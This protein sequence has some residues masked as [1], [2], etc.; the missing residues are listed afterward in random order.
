M[1]TGRL[2]WERRAP[3]RIKRS[4]CCGLSIRQSDCASCARGRCFR[5]NCKAARRN[6]GVRTCDATERCGRADSATGAGAEST[7]GAARIAADRRQPDV[8]GGVSERQPQV[9]LLADTPLTGTALPELAPHGAG[10]ADT[11]TPFLNPVPTVVTTK[12]V[13]E[14]LAP[15]TPPSGNELPS[16][17]T[18]VTGSRPDMPRFSPVTQS[19]TPVS[20]SQRFDVP[21]SASQRF[22]APTPPLDMICHRCRRW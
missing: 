3:R 18:V 5:S 14:M 22:E 7:A 16:V 4:R 20:S 10:S 8:R 2:P 9:E 21:R 1:L 15:G 13:A 6:F 17:P 19:H 11:P 12:G